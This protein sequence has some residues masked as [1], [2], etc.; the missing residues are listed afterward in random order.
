MCLPHPPDKKPLKDRDYV[1]LTTVSLVY[2]TVLG[3][4]D[5]VSKYLLDENVLMNLILSV[6]KANS[7]KAVTLLDPGAKF[8]FSVKWLKPTDTGAH[9]V[10]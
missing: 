7:P 5:R 6:V 9:Q 10:Q 2:S 8:S 1:L 3:P 4:Q